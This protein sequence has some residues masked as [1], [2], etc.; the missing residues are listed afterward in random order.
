MALK[1]LIADLTEV[2]EALRAH[3]T[4]K[5]GAYYLDLDDFGKHPGAATLKATLNR[6]N[7]DKDA[8]AAK[9]AEW[10]PKIE[11]LPEDFDADEWERLKSGAEPSEQI[12]TL[13]DQHAR[14]IE[15]MKAKAKADQEALAVQL[16]ERDGYI[17]GTTRDV[18]LSAALDD[19]GF[20]PKHKPMLAKFLADRVKVRRDDGGARSAYVETDLGEV[21]TLD[22]IKDFAAKD[23][24]DYLAKATGPGAPGS[25]AMRNGEANPFASQ[26]WNK[27]R[28]AQLPA[29]KREAFAVAAGFK[30]YATAIRASGAVK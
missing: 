30:N 13:K 22:F 21:S 6:V 4:E 29:E 15:A 16:A 9:V 12:Q 18:A 10:Q 8:L 5:D 11:A 26:H 28:Q 7:K 27:T 1:A 3:Y 25:A 20:D 14:A 24:K 19:A 2:D 23:G 17:D